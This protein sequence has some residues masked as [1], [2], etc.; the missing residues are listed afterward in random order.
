MPASTRLFWL[1][2]AGLGTLL[3]TPLIVTTQPHFASP[4]GKAI[5]FRVGVEV[6]LVFYGAL[7]FLDREFSPPRNPLLWSVVAYLTLLVVATVVSLDPYRSWW[8]TLGRM[9]GAFAILHYAVFFIMLTGLFRSQRDWVV[10]FNISLAVSVLVALYA[11]VERIAQGHPG[12]SSTLD[13][14]PF[15]AA[16]ALLHVFLAGLDIHWVRSRLARAW[17]AAAFGLNLLTLFLATERGAIVGLAAGLLALAVAVLILRVGTAS[18]RKTAKGVIVLLVAAPF[19]LYYARGSAMLKSSYALE[20]LSRVSL[21]DKT[22]ITRLINLGVSGRAVKARPMLGYGPE[23]FF[24]AYNR[25][26]N[27]KQLSHDQGWVDRSHNKLADVLVMQGLIGLV[28]YLGIFVAAGRLLYGALKRKKPDTPSVLLTFALLAAYFVQNL[29]LFDT[30]A[31]YMMFYAVLAWV[32]FM[33]QENPAASPARPSAPVNR[34]EAPPELTIKQ[35]A[36]L[37]L[38]TLG[39]VFSIYNFNIKVFAQVWSGQK[40]S[41]FIGDPQGFSDS[42][43]A[44]LSC[45]SWLTNDV[46]GGLADVLT[47]SGKARDPAYSQAA[48]QVAAELEKQ[49]ANNDL[50]PRTYIRLGALYNLMAYADRSSLP[51]A[52]AVLKALIQ[53]TPKWP[54]SY[55]ALGET[56]LLEGR[57]DEALALLKKAVEIN[58][59]NGVALWMYAFPLIWTHHEQEG[60]T[61]L[62]AALQRYDYH[63]PDDLK[64]LVNT[65]YRLK[66]LPKAIRYEKELV[67]LEPADAAHRYTLATLY[68][69]SGNTVEALQEVQ[70]AAQ[71]DPRYGTAIREFQ[72][73]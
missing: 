72:G 10:F 25:N 58:P 3:L 23:L 5:A 47:E 53:L 37:G 16:Y 42:V 39:M 22:T 13:G 65:Y 55:G 59:D 18:L 9:D 66:D 34:N 44:A 24:V 21:N 62:E 4:M 12:V 27:P 70:I 8:G 56:Y 28:A 57:N 17:C 45:R 19:I 67:E 33:A 50:D 40:A 7:V 36:L 29:F 38:V 14:P 68:R 15:L 43:Q 1:L 49:I 6:L 31:S 64:R 35:Q 71:L 26:F 60:R 54:E 73:K 2:K 52:E 63:N 61:E 41:A 46:A 48:G 32:S 11:V 30:P 51:K 69:A 20:R